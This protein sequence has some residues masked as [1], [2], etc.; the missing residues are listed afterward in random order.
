M[1]ILR[2][3]ALILSCIVVLRL[4]GL[5]LI[6]FILICFGLIKYSNYDVKSFAV[7]YLGVIGVK[8]FVKLLAVGS[9][10]SANSPRSDEGDLGDDE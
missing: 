3:I 6:G 8:Y 10:E 2:L 5:W 4:R 9:N 7:F 1:E